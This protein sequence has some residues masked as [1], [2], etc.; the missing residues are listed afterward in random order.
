MQR[1]PQVPHIYAPAA[2]NRSRGPVDSAA[3]T[4]E[5]DTMSTTKT[6]KITGLAALALVGILTLTACSISTSTAPTTT[7]VA[8][9]GTSD[10]ATAAV[11]TTPAPVET[12]PAPVADANSAVVNGVLYQGTEKAPVKIGTDVPGLAPAAQASVPTK[13]PDASALAKASG[14]YLVLVTPRYATSDQMGTG[15]PV[16]FYVYIYG[17]NEYG[18]WRA[19]VTVPVAT[20]SEGLA[21]PVVL[22]GRTLDRAEYILMTHG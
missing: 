14:K 9:V 8:T 21:T 6:M 15:A 10:V 18:T 16:G 5:L 11:E 17:V 20:K 12:T 19:L 3:D 7:D 13:L 4:R 22:D 2:K 1:I